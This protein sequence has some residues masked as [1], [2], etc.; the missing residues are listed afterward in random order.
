L[1]IMAV[2]SALASLMILRIEGHR[3]HRQQTISFGP[4]LA[5][6]LWLSWLADILQVDVLQPGFW[7]PWN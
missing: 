4:H 6:G 5:I 3:L 7:L 2:L 1:L